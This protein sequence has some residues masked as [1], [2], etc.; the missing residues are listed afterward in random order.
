MLLVR[1]MENYGTMVDLME[2]YDQVSF[3]P[4]D[5]QFFRR[6]LRIKTMGTEI[7]TKESQEE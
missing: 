1:Y 5:R 2:M 3:L 4:A 7:T 6:K